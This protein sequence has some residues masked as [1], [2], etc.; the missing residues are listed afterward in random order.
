MKP[1]RI[2]IIN[3]AVLSALKYLIVCTI[4]FFG[5]GF[6]TNDSSPS[7]SYLYCFSFTAPG[8][9]TSIMSFITPFFYIAPCWI[10]T[11]CYFCIGWTAYKRL[12]G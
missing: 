2:G 3:I 4:L 5:V 11:Y 8:K 7:A 1:I 12:I 10:A 6:Y 9:L